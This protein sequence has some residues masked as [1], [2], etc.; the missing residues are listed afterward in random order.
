MDIEISDD[1]FNLHVIPDNLE[2]DLLRRLDDEF[3]RFELKFMPNEYNI[4][5]LKFLLM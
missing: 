4:I 1:G 2:F 5:K 3:D